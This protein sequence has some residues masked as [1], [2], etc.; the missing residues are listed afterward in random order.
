MIY[1]Y[2][3]RTNYKAKAFKMMDYIDDNVS[4]E[5]NMRILN[6]D[7][8][9]GISIL[10][11]TDIEINEFYNYDDIE[12]SI[13]VLF[14]YS[15]K[16]DEYSVDVRFTDIGKSLTLAKGDLETVTEVL[17]YFL[18]NPIDALQEAGVISRV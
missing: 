18:S 9:R 17:D 2:E 14:E 8:F 11:P 15:Y 6:A 10:I 13:D 4:A 12:S 7:S 3:E 16:T 1:I 5:Y